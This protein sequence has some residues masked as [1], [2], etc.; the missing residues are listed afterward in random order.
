M[1][2]NSQTNPLRAFLCACFVALPAMVSA[3]TLRI[4]GTGVALGGMKLLGA[5]YEAQHP[6]ISIEILPSLGSSGGVKALMAGAIDLSVSSRPLKSKETAKGAT[7]RLYATTPLALVTATSTETSD[8]TAAQLVAFYTGALTAWP[9][10][11]AARIVLRPISETDTQILSGLS[12]D[13]GAAVAAAQARDGLL[14]A[15]NDQD[16][17]EVLETTPGS[18]GLVALGQISTEDR[19]LKVLSF[20]GALPDAEK[21]GADN[22]FLFKSLFVVATQTP[23]A[24]AQQFLEFVFS[25][26]AQKILKAHDH[27]PAG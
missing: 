14:T 7:A 20:N 21:P 5:A 24:E 2:N 16:N 10:G 22:T 4:G 9:N 23:S 25:E 15:V 27:M 12:P 8:V 6:A 18:L 3:E 1:T 11:K 19:D 26:Q 17:A 13:M